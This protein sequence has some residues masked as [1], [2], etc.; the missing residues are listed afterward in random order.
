MLF[1]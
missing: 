1:Q